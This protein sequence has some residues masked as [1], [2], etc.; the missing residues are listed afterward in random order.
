[1]RFWNQLPVKHVY[2][3]FSMLNQPN[4]N[5]G[6]IEWGLNQCWINVWLSLKFQCNFNGNHIW[7]NQRWIHVLDDWNGDVVSTAISSSAFNVETTSEFNADSTNPFNVDSM[8]FCYLGC[9]SKQW[10]HHNHSRRLMVTNHDTLCNKLRNSL[11]NWT[12]FVVT[13]EQTAAHLSSL[14]LINEGWLRDG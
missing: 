11:H 10:N 5:N 13:R 2:D 1:M 4:F 14:Q 9:H 7:L 6:T 3:T 8:P 12:E